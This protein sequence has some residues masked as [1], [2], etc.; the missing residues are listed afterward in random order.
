MNIIEDTTVVGVAGYGHL[1][2]SIA[3]ALAGNG[4][5]KKRILVSCGGSVETLRR[6]ADDGFAPSLRSTERLAAEADVVILAARPQSLP[7]FAEL[8]LKGCAHLLSFMAGVPLSLLRRLFGPEARR[9]M[10]SGPET[11]AAG[12]GLGVCCPADPAASAVLRAAGLRLLPVSGE[13]ELDSFT[14]GICLPPILQN[15]DIGADERR[16]ALEG[17]TRRFPLYGELAPWI[18]RLA[19]RGGRDEAALANVSTKGGVTEA[20]TE[21]LR[22]GAS[23]SAAIEAGLERS[24]R[25]GGEMLVKFA[26]LERRAS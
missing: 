20:M 24:R 12:E 4:M 8:R 5:P 10:C 17:L 18:E 3:L 11:I 21:A 13:E 1:G 14:A 15:I 2:R 6:V 7:E 22:G 9:V 23:F 19:S 26:A 16:A 25:I